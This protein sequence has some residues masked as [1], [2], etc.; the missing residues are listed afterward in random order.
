MDL[1][2]LLHKSLLPIELTDPE[3]QQLSESLLARPARSIRKAIHLSQKF[4]SFFEALSPVPWH[5]AG[6]WWDELRGRP[7]GEPLYAAGGFYIQDAASMLPLTLL[8]PQPGE[9]I[10]DLCAAPGGKATA[11]AEEL[12]ESGWLL[13][14]ETIQSR[15]APLELT[16]A[17]TGS[18][19]YVVSNCD[20]DFLAE[21]VPNQ[22][23]AI[24]CDA[25]C[26]GQ[27]LIGKGK[28][29]LSSISSQAIELNASR[30]TRILDAAAQLV[31]PGGRIVYSTC[32]LASAENE[33]QAT[34]FIARHPDWYIE[35]PAE[36]QTRL[37]GRSP[38]VDF[39][40]SNLKSPLHEG[41][42]RIWPHRDHCAGGFAVVLVRKPTDN[43]TETDS[44]QA[45]ESSSLQEPI[46]AIEEERGHYLSKNRRKHPAAKSDKRP[47]PMM[48][49][50]VA[51]RPIETEQWGSLRAP[52]VVSGDMQTFAWP[53]PPPESWLAIIHG[54]PEIAYRKGEHWFP[55]HALALRRSS[56]WSPLT[57]IEL[58]KN[59]VIRY[60]AGEALAIA[61]RSA[62][63]HNGWALATWEG[64][65]L[66]WLKVVDGVGKNHLPK[67]ARSH[68]Q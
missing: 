15:L 51:P 48:R 19:R 10:C 11:I 32:T 5:A 13:A 54:G 43:S 62:T 24:L 9:I 4:D 40:L 66:G 41:C 58:S 28:Q 3:L 39:V 42:Y 14:N 46:E 67:G 12:G 30:Q 64:E 2:S 25:P 16:L 60:M 23:D 1:K 27:T 34:H 17:R 59:E 65:P 33:L 63:T 61:Q 20:P 26:S 36:L 57:T 7:G 38:Q 55:S 68:L 50:K 52:F 49:L 47:E 22:F 18:E 35:T 21:Q 56:N 45:L 31:R 44:T 53:E 29:S 37:S 8:A 6:Y